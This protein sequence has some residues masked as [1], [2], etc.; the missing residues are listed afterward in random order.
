MYD[1][2]VI[3]PSKHTVGALPIRCLASERP[4]RYGVVAIGSVRSGTSGRGGSSSSSTAAAKEQQM[5][6]QHA[7]QQNLNQKAPAPSV[8]AVQIAQAT[9]AAQAA[10]AAQELQLQQLRQLQQQQQYQHQ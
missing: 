6:K 10:Q 3:I 7:I 9:Q 2:R 4:S 8:Q 1:D 5:K